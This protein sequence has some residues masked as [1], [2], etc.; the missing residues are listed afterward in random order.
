MIIFDNFLLQTTH[1]RFAVIFHFLHD[2]Q[3]NIPK[4]IE[5]IVE[6]TIFTASFT[7]LSVPGGHFGVQRKMAAAERV[8]PVRHLCKDLFFNCIVILVLYDTN[9][10][11]EYNFVYNYEIII[12]V[13]IFEV[14]RSF[15]C[16]YYKS[17]F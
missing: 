3:E 10:D 2:S 9:L 16:K 5:S 15:V 6:C 12:L 14:L 11:F 8:K 1:T 13:L 17:H 7:G 4:T